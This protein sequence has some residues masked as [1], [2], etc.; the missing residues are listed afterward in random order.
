MTESIRNKKVHPWTA[1]PH[2]SLHQLLTQKYDLIPLH[3]WQS[4]NS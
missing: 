4:I 1:L 3:W 2:G